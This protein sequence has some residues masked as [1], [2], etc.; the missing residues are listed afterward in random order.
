MQ[1]WHKNSHVK[2][3][4]PINLTSYTATK[5]YV[6]TII[7]I[8]ITGC[9]AYNHDLSNS[10]HVSHSNPPKESPSLCMMRSK[11]NPNG[12]IASAGPKKVSPRRGLHCLMRCVGCLAL[13][14]SDLFLRPIPGMSQKVGAKP[15]AL[16]PIWPRSESAVVRHPSGE[17]PSSVTN[18][19]KCQEN[20]APMAHI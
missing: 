18:R 15:F 9:T 3:N 7:P 4:S 12:H 14:P 6:G 17:V 11:Q 10:H 20:L 8:K 2:S 16:W 5:V 1:L 13:F 19:G